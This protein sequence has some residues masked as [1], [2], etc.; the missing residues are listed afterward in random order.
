MSKRPRDEA[1]VESLKAILGDISTQ[2]CES[3][4][5]RANNNIEAAIDLYFSNP[6]VVTTQRKKSDRFNIG[7]LVI[8]GWSLYVG[9][10]PV[11]EGDK[12]E[13]VKD[14]K[15]TDTTNR[16][17]RFTYQGITVGR[18]PKDIA[19][20]VSIL[21]D[22][23]ICQFEGSVVWCP[24]ELRM[25][26]DVILTIQCFILPSAMRINKFMSAF[27]PTLKKRQRMS[28]A[29]QDTATLKK[30]SLIQLFRNLGMNP[31]RSA[32]RNMIGKDNTWDMILQSANMKE[33]NNAAESDEF[34]E[35]DEGE[36]NKQVSDDQLNTIYEKA[37]I[38]DAQITAV[39]QPDS[40]ALQL[41]EYQKRALAWM[42]A[43]EALQHQ[44]GDI[45]M[46]AMHP[47]W[48]EYCFPDKDCEYQFFYFN[49]YTGE[50]SLDFPEANSQER[51]GI[52]AD[53]QWRDEIMNGSKPGTIRVEVY[54]GDDRSVVS[55]DR[56]GD[57]NGSAPDVLITTYGVLMNEWTRMQLDSTH[58]TTLLYNIEFWRVILD[59]AHQIKNP[60]SKTSQACK[61]LQATRRWAVTGTPIQNKLDD[62]FALVRFLKHEPW[63]NHSFWRAFITIP[64]EK[65]D[66]KAL[67]AVQTVLE[68][69][70]LRRTK[71][72][73]DSKGQPMVP[74]PPKRIDIEYLSFSPEE[75]DI[76]D[77][78]YNDSKI[79]FSYF[80]QAGHIGRNY[81][82]IFQLLTRLRQICCHPYLA[83]QNSQTAGNAEVK[84]EGGKNISLEDLI[85]GH[86]TKPS[87]SSSLS[88]QDQSN[89]R[90]NVL[91]NLLAIQ[92]GS[93]AT[94]ST[95]EKMI[96]EETMPPVPEECPICFESFD[97][98]IA[99]PCMHMAC[100]L[101]VMDYF[102]LTFFIKQKKEDQGLP[103]D[104]PICRTGP[105]LQ[106]QL[107]EIAQGRAEEED[108]EK[109]IKIDV[110]K[111]VGGYKPSTKINALIKLLH[112]Y[113]KESHKTVVF[114]QFTSFLD[115][116]GEALDYERIHFTRLDGSHSQAQRE[117]VLSTFAKM[118]QNGANVLLIS[119]RAGGVGLN[120]TCASR[121]VMMDPWWNFAIES[122]AIDRVHRL[123]QLKEVKVTRF[124]V[125]GTV[126]ERILEIQDSKHTL[127]NDLYMSRDDSKNRKMDELKLLFSKKS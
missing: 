22:L 111:A 13:I 33:E 97:S 112:Q 76:Y 73:K 83:L 14:K 5:H 123:G 49:P 119:L 2:L 26:E 86:H 37:Q 57:W 116:V 23:N 104:C 105:I 95:V 54:Y 100:R 65:K 82:S 17:V 101:C 60:A 38:F 63:A 114:S 68:P 35:L 79:K 45:D 12:I 42:M 93:S 118:D 91:Q 43:K 55:L 67:T 61:D 99:M 8:T 52:L 41:K 75:Q 85:A 120:L 71:N 77:A 36:E 24:E 96:A 31:V 87:S 102:Q 32:I 10:S 9:K 28:S 25:G 3:L 20:Y 125:R 7:D 70:I 59:E 107:L 126:E 108:D 30:T 127:V 56:L 62:L 40:L 124:I 113:N 66:P 11:K 103:G 58:K 69:I 48:E 29:D 115:I 122:Q 19:N 34:Q 27:V 117:K 15:V 44:D 50:L 64:F 72:M 39:E 4:L 6:P 46:R 92:Q 88:K 1:S 16:I 78:I 121:V 84:A 53:A 94:K 74:L 98:M 89:Y 80:C 18:L 109:G 90:L 51:G 110:R 106:N 21:I 47:L 81:A